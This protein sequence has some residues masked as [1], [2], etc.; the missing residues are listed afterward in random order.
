M[1][2]TSRLLR[3]ESR[4]FKSNGWLKIAGLVGVSLGSYVLWY[5]ARSLL[6]GNI[7]LVTKSASNTYQVAVQPVGFWVVFLV[8][9]LVVLVLVPLGVWALKQRS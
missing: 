8:Y 4:L 1:L 3:P 2:Q 6:V 9:S 5:L 7:T